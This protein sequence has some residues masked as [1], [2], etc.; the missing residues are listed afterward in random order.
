MSLFDVF[1]NRTKKE[2]EET[3]D[4]LS[5]QRALKNAGI[6]EVDKENSVSQSNIRK[7]TDKD[8]EN[9]KKTLEENNQK[10]QGNKK[11]NIETSNDLE[12]VVAKSKETKNVSK[13]KKKNVVSSPIIISFK[14]KGKTIR[15]D[16]I[17]TGNFGKMLTEEDLPKIRGYERKGKLPQI[18]IG[19][20]QQNVT[21][22]YF[23]KK[24]KVTLVPTTE[25]LVP[26]PN[27]ATET[28]ELRVGEEINSKNFPVVA[29]YYAYKQRKYTAPAANGELKIAYGPE[30]QT[31]HVIYTT[32]SGEVLRDIV[33][34]GKTDEPYV[35]KP[36][37]YRFYGY[38][39]GELPKNLSGKFQIKNQNVVIKY[40]PL[41][42]K[43]SVSFLDET[44]NVIHK[45]LTYEDG[46][47]KGP[48]S[49]KIPQIDGYE[50][51][52]DPNV[53]SGKF[54]HLEEK[55]VLR[56]K[57]ATTSFKINFWFDREQTKK[58][59][60]S[61]TIKGIVQN[62]YNIKIPSIPGYE[63]NLKLISGQFKIDKNED[64][65]VIYTPIKC[66]LEIFF[67][68]EAGRSIQG[69]EPIKVVGDW[70]STYDVTLPKISG[71]KEPKTK[72][73][74]K[75]ETDKKIVVNYQPKKVKIKINF[76]DSKSQKEIE[77]FDAIEKN[78]IVG[79]TYK[80]EPEIID[81]YRLR[82]MPA[83][84]A[85]IVPNENVDVT[86]I[87]EPYKSQI[88][89]HYY[90]VT[91][92]TL[93]NN[94]VIEGYFGKKIEYEPEKIPG[95]T[96]KESSIPLDGRFEA[97]RLD[98]DLIYQPKYITFNLV[99]IDQFNQL[100]SPDF[101]QKVTGLVGQSF[102]IQMPE[103]PGFTIDTNIINGRIKTNY[104]NR[105][106][107]IKYEPLDASVTIR[108][109]IH[110]GNKDRQAPFADTT[111]N[112][113]TGET[114]EYDVVPLTGYHT[115]TKKITGVFDT[116][117]RTIDVVY[118]VNSEDYLIQF[119]DSKDN[120]VGGIGERKGY[121]GDEISVYEFLPEGFS[122]PQGMEYSKIVLTGQHVYKVQVVPQPMTI[123]LIA[124]TEDGE[125]LNN[126]RQQIIGEFH[127]KQTVTVPRIPG[128][129]PI[130][131]D[132]INL[133]FDD[134]NQSQIIVKYRPEERYLTVRYISTQG[135]TLLPPDK[136]VGHYQ[137]SYEVKAKKI[138]GY[139][140]V[141]TQI[142]HGTFDHDNLDTA[143]IYRAGSDEYSTAMVS[144]DDIINSQQMNDDSNE[145]ATHI[146][147]PASQPR[148]LIN[149]IINSE[150][151]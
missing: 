7:A 120:L 151:D 145:N 62:Q 91:Y 6:S 136:I 58:A 109:L 111:I 2:N 47:F 66:E 61:M 88:V 51:T 122:L 108:T 104:N 4:A 100:I 60:E 121:F 29:G 140:V 34:H 46:Y 138:P 45:P 98:I 20:K 103:I 69:V 75:F 17:F 36:D 89:V 71:F 76:V 87:Y 144:L 97:N 110:G 106:F 52:S 96:F 59:Q 85:G 125:S 119:V 57:K 105:N 64:V 25:D 86:F 49:V 56:F 19:K 38:E 150:E 132:Q 123:D 113:K 21:L 35:I 32:E 101:N 73:Q 114:F 28:I 81:G 99:P 12:E 40:I 107:K 33:K 117:W 23:I 15:N 68:D 149:D 135:E 70:G 112:G 41:K 1:N 5:K 13:E 83:N 124:Q 94:K 50:L 44:G 90:D 11:E 43:L 127:Q 55:V 116:A 54:A 129:Q 102:S 10:N 128:Y 24:V 126:V 143:F 92:N 141:D 115:K 130:K 72:I 84:A 18:K 9:T 39:I 3:K 93:K 139:F 134:L 78:A 42:T 77:H 8:K 79:S 82:E 30:N 147:R 22:E 74:G 67:E 131:S 37:K 27:A 137:E 31:L 63:S 133:A 148:N 53:L 146:V 16:Y 26:I 142:K 80:I 48:Y 118:E 95:Y 14:S 65:N